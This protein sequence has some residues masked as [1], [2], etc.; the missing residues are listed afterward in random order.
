MSV[1]IDSEALVLISPVF[2]VQTQTS[3]RVTGASCLNW[4]KE[5]VNIKRKQENKSYY[6]YKIL[7]YFGFFVIVFC[8]THCST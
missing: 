2:N 8:A 1:K 6:Y 7:I 3:Q 4:K 5:N